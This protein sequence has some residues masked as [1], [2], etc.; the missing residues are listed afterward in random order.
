MAKNFVNKKVNNYLA[1]SVIFIAIS[2]ALALVPQSPLSIM[3]ILDKHQ[4]LTELNQRIEDNE[5]LIERKN[6]ELANMKQQSLV[7]QKKKA[8]L[9]EKLNN[10]NFDI[11]MPSILILLEQN[12]KRY[13]LELEIVY[14]QIKEITA[15]Q[16]VVRQG[17][18]QQNA[19]SVKEDSNNQVSDSENGQA[20]TQQNSNN[21]KTDNSVSGTQDS[22]NNTSNLQQQLE[23][24]SEIQGNTNENIGQVLDILESD[25]TS[26][27]GISITAIPIKVKGKYATI[28]SYLNFLDKID[29]IEPIY[30]EMTS[31]G[32]DIDS[33]VILYVFHS[34]RGVS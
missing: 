32:T 1:L 18:V 3:N 25:I 16:D 33:L 13:N 5:M 12:A 4:F 8:L 31:L 17:Q 20:E 23:A 29:F 21:S 9:E 11:H 22:N 2:V 30:I 24:S 28:R 10:M 7:F 6:N 34:N 27:D 26:I 14:N 15:S 19:D